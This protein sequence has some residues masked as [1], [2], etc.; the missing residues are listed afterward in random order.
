M[1]ANGVS[2]DTSLLRRMSNEISDSI[3][4]LTDR[5]IGFAGVP[6]NIDS[7]KQLAE[8]LFDRLGLES[9]KSGKTQRSTDAEVLEYLADRHEIVPLLMQY[10]QL[11][12]LKNTYIDKLP[13]L[14]NPR[15]DECM[16]RLIRP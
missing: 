13:Q 2:L 1:E 11:V 6:F 4:E 14:I 9:V 7:T 5:I 15:T 16:P 3:N 10:R 8:I 12:K